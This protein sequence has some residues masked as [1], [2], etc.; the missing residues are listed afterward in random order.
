VFEDLAALNDNAG[1]YLERQA[2]E[3]RKL[4]VDKLTILTREGFSADEIIKAAQETPNCLIAMCSHGR[5]GM[6][7]WLLGSVT[8]TVAR[9]ASC[10]VLVLRSL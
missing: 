3:I 8:E 5:S 6:N 4:G 7:R 9:H 1:A 10:P 2:A